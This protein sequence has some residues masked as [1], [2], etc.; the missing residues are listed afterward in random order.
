MPIGRVVSLVGAVVLVAAYAMPWFAVDVGGGNSIT[1]SG[2][3]LG[4]F[5][6]GTNDLR[7]FMPGAAGGPQEVAQLRALVLLFP[8]AGGLA[9]LAAVATAWWRRRRPADALIVLL[10]AVPLAALAIGLGQLPAGSRPEIGLWAIGGG[11][12]LVVLGALADWALDRSRPLGQ[13]DEVAEAG[14]VERGEAGVA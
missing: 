1:L 14:A 11:A 5:L 2:Q 7:R 12:L 13:R 4:R 8:S 6:A 10:G 3:F 9:G